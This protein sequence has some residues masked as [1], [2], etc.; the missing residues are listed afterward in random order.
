ME[1]R[2]E[3]RSE[4]RAAMGNVDELLRHA[5]DSINDGFFILDSDWRFV[6]INRHARDLIAGGADL[7]G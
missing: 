7:T 6:F 5:V 4:S 2:T 1:N 3:R